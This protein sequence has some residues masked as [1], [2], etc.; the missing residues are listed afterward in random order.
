MTLLS[1][2]LSYGCTAIEIQ[3]REHDGFEQSEQIVGLIKRF[4]YRSIHTADL[5][6][7]HD[8]KFEVEY[9]SNLLGVI[10]AHAI[11]VHPHTMITWSWLRSY[12][13]TKTSFENMDWRKPFAKTPEDMA[14]VFTN[15]PDA[16]WTYDLNHVFTN[17]SSMKLSK[18]FY[19][20][21]GNLGH[22]H[23]S[24]FKDDHLPHTKLFETRQ[25]SIITS[26]ED[27]RP[28]I[29]ESF[30]IEDIHEFKKEYDYVTARL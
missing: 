8:N 21:L 13:G 24:G 15:F 16:R 12:F 5:I 30:G 2:M 18:D 22:Y 17:D 11:T 23:I 26:V 4:T 3:A 6:S 25:D 14:K 20:T 9:Y 1:E 29:I 28:I 10:D 19:T 27:E 7:V